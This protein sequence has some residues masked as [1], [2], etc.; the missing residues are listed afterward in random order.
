[1]TRESAAH[2]RGACLHLLGM[3]RA[4]RAD[5]PEAQRGQSF[6]ELALFVPVFVLIILGAA[7]FGF[8]LRAHTNLT[9]VTQQAAQYLLNHPAN[10]T[11]TP[12]AQCTANVVTTYLGAH[13]FANA[14][15]TVSFQQT[16]DGVQKDVISVSYPFNMTL[17]VPGMISAGAMRGST[18]SLGATAS[19]IAATAA[20]TITQVTQLGS[21]VNT[22]DTITWNPPLNPAGVTLKYRVFSFGTPIT[23]DQALPSIATY[24]DDC[25]AS[26]V[27]CRQNYYYYRVSA[28]Q[29][30]GLESPLS[31]AAVCPDV[32]N[33]GNP[34]PAFYP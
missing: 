13:G 12:Y 22:T 28:V 14:T 19:T 5:L 27:P 7:N 33:P 11:C 32:L 23:P 16:P 34:C 3:R 8:A 4:L 31:Q 10:G 26:P 6:T 18:L 25:S 30:N 17:P 21:G 24:S 9:Q 1:M 15:A 29:P 20:P 2:R